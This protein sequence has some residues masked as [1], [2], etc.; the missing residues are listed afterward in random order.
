MKDSERERQRWVCGFLFLTI[1]FILLISM[2]FF[3]WGLSE[4]VSVRVSCWVV[5]AF[6]GEWQCVQL[7]HLM[8]DETLWD[9][10][11][12]EKF[13]RLS[14]HISFIMFQTK[15]SMISSSLVL[16]FLFFHKYFWI[17]LFC[18]FPGIAQIKL[19][20]DGLFIK[21]KINI[22]KAALWVS[23]LD[24]LSVGLVYIQ[25]SPVAFVQIGWVLVSV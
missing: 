2:I 3:R 24:G 17:I 14:V 22:K 21:I 19:N 7:A 1:C 5:T 9:D 12:K 13:L 4:W 16:S 18:T 15:F 23:W 25:S 6:T 11:I 10:E 8:P 20:T